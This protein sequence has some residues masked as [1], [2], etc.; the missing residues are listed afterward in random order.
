MLR[1]WSKPQEAEIRVALYILNFLKNTRKRAVKLDIYILFN[2]Y[3]I[4]WNIART[5]IILD[6]MLSQNI[7]YSITM[8]VL[9]K[10]KF[11]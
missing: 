11:P 8:H 1:S 7:T 4:L 2:G 5:I 6:I 3:L 9:N 10:I